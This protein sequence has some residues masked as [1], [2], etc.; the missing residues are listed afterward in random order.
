MKENSEGGRFQ[1]GDGRLV[2]GDRLLRSIGRQLVQHSS[3]P[4]VVD[5]LIYL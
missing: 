5:Y 4:T 2:Q 3:F 1:G